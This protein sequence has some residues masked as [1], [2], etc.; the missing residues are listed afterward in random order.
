M[1]VCN[2]K[3]SFKIILFVAVFATTTNAAVFS[4]LTGAPLSNIAG[5][6]VG[7]DKLKGKYAMSGLLLGSPVLSGKYTGSGILDL[8]KGG[9]LRNA[10]S[11]KLDGLF[12]PLLAVEPFKYDPL[13]K[14][15]KSTGLFGTK[16]STALTA[17]GDVVSSKLQQKLDALS[18]GLGVA[19][20]APFQAAA[21]VDGVVRTK[22]NIVRGAIDSSE[23]IIESNPQTAAMKTLLFRALI[24]HVYMDAGLNA[25]ISMLE[26]ISKRVL[27]YKKF[28]KPFGIGVFDLVT[29]LLDRIRG[30][31][32]TVANVLAIPARVFNL[33]A[34]EGAEQSTE[35]TS[36]ALLFTERI[37]QLQNAVR[38]TSS[39][40]STGQTNFFSAL[41]SWLNSFRNSQGA[42]RV[43]QA[44][45]WRL[46]TSDYLDRQ[47]RNLERELNST[48]NDRSL[49][50]IGLLES[51]SAPDVD[52]SRARTYLSDLGRVTSGS[53]SSAFDNYRGLSG[54]VFD[55]MRDLVVSGVTNPL[56][57]QRA[58]DLLGNGA[59]NTATSIWDT[60]QSAFNRQ[61]QLASL[62]N[63]D[64]QSGTEAFD[65]SF[66]RLLNLFQDFNPVFPVSV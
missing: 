43:D 52:I 22:E 6:F 56:D 47:T 54:T 42:S 59:A 33:Q 20:Q 28:F 62:F 51:S 15:K 37:A 2:A 1:A 8:K 14:K 64:L 19:K 13:A 5:A 60:Y 35:S 50:L 4:S 7:S 41:D 57:Y 55:S 53:A 36:E 49:S 65:S 61:Q 46:G 30:A 32:A 16:T 44:Q 34:E 12:D 45:R 11:S 24:Y 38:G 10:L 21:V 23:S 17:G 66:G 40:A 27:S 48:L 31:T 18:S 26:Q 58:G 25:R 63:L 3:Y 39:A 9:I 29:P